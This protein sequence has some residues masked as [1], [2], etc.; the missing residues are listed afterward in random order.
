[1]VEK[2]VNFSH[3]NFVR[4]NFKYAK[5]DLDNINFFSSDFQSLKDM[6]V[7]TLKG[8]LVQ[9]YYNLKQT[10]T[11]EYRKMLVEEI[12][13]WFREKGC[14]WVQNLAKQYPFKFLSI[15]RAKTRY[16][17]YIIITYALE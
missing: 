12:V 16:V 5:A 11:D 15:S 8:R 14:N 13:L 17:Y 7:G 3:I 2:T 4:L 6:L 1:M 10:L 9:Q